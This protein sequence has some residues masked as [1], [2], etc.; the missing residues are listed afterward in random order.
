MEKT[1]QYLLF[2][3]SVVNSHCNIVTLRKENEVLCITQDLALPT[4]ISP[5]FIENST[6]SL[7]LLSGEDWTYDNWVLTNASNSLSGPVTD[8]RWEN[9]ETF[10][11]THITFDF[12]TSVSLSLY[13]PVKMK[14]RLVDEI[15]GNDVPLSVTDEKWCHISIGVKN[16][17]V[18][19]ILNGEVI[20][21][22]FGFNPH[23]IVIENEKDTFWKIH[24]YQFMMSE[25]VSDG[26][27]STLTLK[28]IHAE[29]SCFF[30]Y[31][32]LCEKCVLTIPELNRIYSSTYNPSF[33]NSWQVYQLEIETGIEHLS[34][35]KTTTDNSTLGYW[36]IDLHE[37]PTNDIVGHKV[38]SSEIERNNY[39][40]HVLNHEYKMESQMEQNNKRVNVESC[41]DQNCKCIWGY[42]DSH[43]KASGL[44]EKNCKWACNLCNKI[45]TEDPTR[46]PSIDIAAAITIS[47]SLILGMIIIV[48]TIIRW[49]IQKEEN[50]TRKNINESELDR[51]QK[52][53]PSSINAV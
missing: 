47:L 39:L 50:I 26:K 51:L 46:G 7:S 38:N 33:L 49:I 43:Y 13:S 52:E 1:G 14:I 27:P 48:V 36:G 41:G 4:F 11:E 24:D 5:P 3:M 32:S 53:I 12:V 8:K 15:G 40:C 18:S 21:L 31:L 25:K 29:N 19:C 17:N 28:S 22:L 23:K 45:T 16:N 2:L 42:S 20:E 6:K 30:L 9:F 37:C 10:A 34:F 44:S 35:Y